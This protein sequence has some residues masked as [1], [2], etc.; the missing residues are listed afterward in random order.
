[1]CIRDRTTPST[2][3]VS[4]TWNINDRFSLMAEGVHT[5]WDSLREIRIEF[6]NPLQA[7][8]VE[9][10]NCCLLYTSRCV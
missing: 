3:T 9:D 4:V 10:Y 8:A 6:D 1:M 2:H 5:G 7:D